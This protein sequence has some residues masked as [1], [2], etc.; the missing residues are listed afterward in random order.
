[1]I[2]GQR[3]TLLEEAMMTPAEANMWVSTHKLHRRIY[4]KSNTIDQQPTRSRE[5]YVNA[6]MQQL[7]LKRQV[8]KWE[9]EGMKMALPF[10]LD[11]MKSYYHKH[12]M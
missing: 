2:Q 12:V 5:F 9:R 11:T 4:L 7:L 8:G 1:M 6:L 10:F 3:T